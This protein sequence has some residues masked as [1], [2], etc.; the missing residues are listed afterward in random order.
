MLF[1]SKK[2][3]RDWYRFNMIGLYG[4]SLLSGVAVR[5]HAVFGHFFIGA[6]CNSPGL[7]FGCIDYVGLRAPVFDDRG[8]TARGRQSFLASAMGGKRTLRQWMFRCRLQ[9]MER[10]GGAIVAVVVGSCAS[11][12]ASSAAAAS[13]AK[14]IC[15]DYSHQV[16]LVSS[17]DPA[18]EQ[19]LF[20][21]D[22]PVVALF[23]RR[24]R[25]LI[26][27]GVV[28]SSDDTSPTFRALDLGFAKARPRA[29]ILEGFPESWGPNPARIVSKAAKPPNSAN[30]YDLGE[31]MYAA[32]LALRTGAVIWGSEPTDAELR[33]QLVKLGFKRRDIF[34]AAMF[35]P[36]AQDLEAKQFADVSDPRFEKS[37]RRWAEINAPEYDATAPRDSAAF[38]D[39][40]KTHYGH[41]LADDPEWFDR[42]GPG[43][44]GLAGQI[45][46]AS[47]RIRDKHMV[48]E[49]LRLACGNGPVLLV[50]GRSHLSSQWQALRDALGRPRVLTVGQRADS[51]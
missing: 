51:R 26:F 20:P 18:R 36:L 8:P 1:T 27:V 44:K 25:S 2:Y 42:G 16:S 34:F 7:L 45:A 12:L 3:G 22:A 14:A 37:Y 46:R 31:D 33:D 11:A 32:R 35:G 9:R 21:T 50:A 6:D 17:Y 49:A 28:H 38:G 10:L 13:N 48:A 23:G 15:A 4:F 24:P 19:K 5:R 41:T 47:N 43:Q 29:V 39:W 40:F 30:S